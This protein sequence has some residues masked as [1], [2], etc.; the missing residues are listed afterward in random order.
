M[1]LLFVV[2]AGVAI[3]NLHI[4]SRWSFRGLM[5]RLRGVQRAAAAATA[6]SNLKGQRRRFYVNTRFK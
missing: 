6:Y 5:E 1:L 4:Y 2:L 3:I